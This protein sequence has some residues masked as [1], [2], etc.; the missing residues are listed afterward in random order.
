M[1]HLVDILIPTYNRPAALAVTLTS[2][3]FQEFDRF[4]VVISDQTRDYNVA[5]AGEV[6]ASVRVLEARGHP[7]EIHKHLPSRG[8]AE[9]RNFLLEQAQAPYALF[10]DD[11]LILEPYVTGLMLD[12]LRS[13]GCGFA[14]SAVIG[15]SFTEDIRPHEQAVEFWEGPVQPETVRPDTP[16]W[17]RYRLHNAANVYHLQQRLGASPAQP[18]KY[19]VAWV[20]GCVLYNVQ[21]LRS[22]GGFSFWKDLPA[23]HCGEDVLAQ[24]RVMAAYGGLGVLPSGVYHQELPTTV[25][26]RQHNAPRILNL[27]IHHHMLG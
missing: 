20:G 21:K 3:A 22:V 4:R 7:V 27:N 5:D 24:Q 12:L 6:K 15:L 14:G 11:D 10:L 13:E 16:E 25:P 23:N 17:E 2:L 1:T 26:D 18:R 19:K 9:Q 8:M